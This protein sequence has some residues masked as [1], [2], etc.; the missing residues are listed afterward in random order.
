MTELQHRASV[1][2]AENADLEQRLARTRE[3]VALQS[4]MAEEVVVVVR[5]PWRE[6]Y[7][8]IGSDIHLSSCTSCPCFRG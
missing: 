1:L 3:N 5:L 8:L 4:A 6:V 2:A 7:S